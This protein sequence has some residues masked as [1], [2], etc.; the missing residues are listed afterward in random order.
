[1]RGDLN[2]RGF[3]EKR[4]LVLLENQEKPT[5]LK[6]VWGK[7]RVENQTGLVMMLPFAFYPKSHEKGGQ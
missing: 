7:M 6:W 3:E 5:R 1:M 4:S 2:L